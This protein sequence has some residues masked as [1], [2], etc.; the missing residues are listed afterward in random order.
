MVVKT[1]VASYVKDSS[2]ISPLNWPNIQ[3]NLIFDYD[4]GVG[5]ML[6]TGYAVHPL[7]GC[8]GYNSSSIWWDNNNKYSIE[9]LVHLNITPPPVCAWTSSGPCYPAGSYPFF[10]LTATP[11]TDRL[12]EPVDD[13]NGLHW[14]ESGKYNSYIGGW[15]EQVQSGRT[16]TFLLRGKTDYYGRQGVYLQVGLRGD[17]NRYNGYPAK[18]RIVGT[19]RG[20]IREVEAAYA[21]YFNFVNIPITDFV[22]CKPEWLV[23]EEER[24][25]RVEDLQYFINKTEAETGVTDDG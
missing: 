21:Q 17:Y 9:L 18:Y 19:N 24:H 5:I 23:P 25:P 16:F 15:T 6:P 8:P 1:R 12:Q 3:C 22:F 14:F 10:D 4:F 7:L 2:Y 20:E 11:I 13:A